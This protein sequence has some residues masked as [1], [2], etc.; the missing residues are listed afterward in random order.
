MGFL[1]N[2]V[3][4]CLSSVQH[5][6]ENLVWIKETGVYNSYLLTDAFVIGFYL[7]LFYSVLSW[8]LSIIT[9]NCSQVDR[10][11]SIVPFI[12]AWH[13][14]LHSTLT[15]SGAIDNRLAVIAVLTT[16]WGV[17]LSYN[18]YRKGGYNMK[19]EDYRW[20]VLRKIISNKI[21]FQL[22]NISFIAFY[23]NFL[24][25]AIT[26][27][28]FFAYLSWNIPWGTLDSVATAF[29]VI[30]L[31]IETI[32]DQQ[33]W[34]YQTEKHRLIK[35]K[36]TLPLIY[37]VGFIHTGLFKYSRHPNFWA[38]QLL[39]WAIY[40][41]SLPGFGILNESVIGTVL[42]TLLFQGST[43]FTEWI[44]TKKYPL[45]KKYQET[46]S[47]FLPLPSSFTVS[48]AELKKNK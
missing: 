16:L 48:P 22:F 24:L 42:L 47:R 1:L 35:A 8:V 2:S 32:A 43:T 36:A 31:L 40:L 15:H 41:F 6:P 13:F 21:L 19:D 3:Q 5:L 25:Y 18:F 46:T 29:F 23:Q 10:L 20:P 11:W 14:L 39:W 34:N 44:S 33:Q 37:S 7:M 45:Y 27:P 17:R 28:V 9:G 38:E 12:Y 4:Q 30:F 26:F